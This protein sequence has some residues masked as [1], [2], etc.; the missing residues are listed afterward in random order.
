MAQFIY[1]VKALYNKKTGKPRCIPL[2][3]CL[4]EDDLYIYN[5]IFKNNN[6]K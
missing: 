1:P 6:K 2:M 3:N 4:N 5:A